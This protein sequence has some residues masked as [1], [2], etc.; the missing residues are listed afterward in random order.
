MIFDFAACFDLFEICEKFKM[1]SLY[2]KSFLSGPNTTTKV[3]PGSFAIICTILITLLA[4][5]EIKIQNF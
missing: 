2:F 1:R 3:F 5:I 4:V